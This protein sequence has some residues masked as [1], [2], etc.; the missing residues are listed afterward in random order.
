MSRPPRIWTLAELFAEKTV[1]VG[2]CKEW[3][4]SM[5]G[6]RARRRMPQINSGGRVHNAR[7]FAWA[8]KHGVH[9]DSLAPDFNVW[10]TCRNPRCIEPSHLKGGTHAQMSADLAAQGAY[11]VGP[12]ALARQERRAQRRAG[13]VNM[14]IARKVRLSTGTCAEVGAAEGISPSLVSLIRRGKS[15]RESPIAVSAFALQSV[16]LGT[17]SANENQLESAA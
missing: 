16:W 2:D 1:E 5:G 6:E 7:R 4:G 14:Y 3:T 9:A 13:K 12:D 17:V 15:W 11:K 10:T 8:L